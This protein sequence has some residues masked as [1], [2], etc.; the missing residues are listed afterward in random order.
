MTAPNLFSSPAARL[1]RQDLVSGLYTAASTVEDFFDPENDDDWCQAHDI[2]K[3]IE[4][5]AAEIERL[6]EALEAAR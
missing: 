4:R 3:L 2:A 5:A 1:R 6:N